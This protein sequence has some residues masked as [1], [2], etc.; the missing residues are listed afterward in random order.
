VGPF[1]KGD[2]VIVPFPYSN[3]K[4]SKRR[5]ALIVAAPSGRDFIAAQITSRPQVDPHAIPITAADFVSG[6]IKKSSYIRPT[7]LFTLD[8]DEVLH[9]AGTVT[10]AKMQEVTDQLVHIFTA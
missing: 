2:V 4:T 1:V 9:R 10:T 8:P 5:P 6:D 7:I 3:L